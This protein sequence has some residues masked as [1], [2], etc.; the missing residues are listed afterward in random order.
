MN[1]KRDLKRGYAVRLTVPCPVGN[2]RYYLR[3]ILD[4]TSPGGWAEIAYFNGS[5]YKGV[6]V[7]FEDL[8]PDDPCRFKCTDC[9][10]AQDKIRSCEKI[11]NIGQFFGPEGSGMEEAA[12]I[13]VLPLFRCKL[14]GVV[15]A[16]TDGTGVFE[17]KRVLEEIEKNCPAPLHRCND[18]ECGICEL[19][20]YREV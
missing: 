5:E 1:Q 6:L 19:A 18:N 3:G 2:S 14:C 10:G 12:L 13:E 17:R 15:V 20:G 8:V 11:R 4:S 7:R 9:T 16:S